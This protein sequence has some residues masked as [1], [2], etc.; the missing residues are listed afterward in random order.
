MLKYKLMEAIK[1]FL[2]KHKWPILVCTI[3]LV[4][5]FFRF[6]KI[7]QIP[8]G[9]FSDEAVNGSNTIEAIYGDGPRVF[10]I[11]NNGREGL[12]INIQ[13]LSVKTFGNFPWALRVVSGFFGSLTVL[14][15]YFLTKEL[16]KSR[17]AAIFASLFMA[18]SFW[19]INFSRIG[20]RAIMA[21]FFLVW[22]FW[23]VWK[24]ANTDDPNYS[25][26]KSIALAII[27]GLLFGL[28]F[29][30]YIA[31]RI[32]P[33]LLLPPLIIFIKKKKYK[34]VIIFTLAMLIA[35]AP[36]FLYFYNNQEQF[37]GR[38][39]QVSIFT[40]ENPALALLK[41]VGITIAM[42]FV[43]G[44]FNWRHNYVDTIFGQNVGSPELWWPVALMFFVGIIWSLKKVFKKGEDLN[45]RLAYIFLWAWMG[46]M[47]LPV[48]I[49]SEGLPHALRAI[50]VIPIA[51]ILAGL[52]IEQ[53]YLRFKEKPRFV[54]FFMAFLVAMLISNA[55][56]KYFVKWANSPKVAESFN[57]D[58]TKDAFYLNS[59]P[60]DTPRYVIMES[61]G[62]PPMTDHIVKFITNSYLP[63]QQEEKNIH[64]IFKRDEGSVPPNAIKIWIR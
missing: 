30:S 47:L 20:F 33:L 25:A 40:A 56:D 17:F 18:T 35:I 14:G 54:A 1:E 50:T 42:F 31:Y 52:G 63:Y 57:A 5:I 59:F 43:V 2:E 4:A 6:Y 49:S 27:G 37:L 13:A 44:D 12:F 38:T 58:A 62:A 61:D 60:S 46:V 39:S 11:D 29:H 10:Y 34:E 32:A 48:V 45:E 55:Y 21:P 36:L 16:F 26:W 7:N 64:Y 22:S 3:F 53:V 8:A 24:M 28:G 19:H 15:L 23:L 9:L 51:M 41:N